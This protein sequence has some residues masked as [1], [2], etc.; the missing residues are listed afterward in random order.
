MGGD[1]SNTWLLT[2]KRKGE[3]G[4]L[5]NGI[6]VFGGLLNLFRDLHLSLLFFFWLLIGILFPLHLTS[7]LL[8]QFSFNLLS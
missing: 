8:R 5:K 3:E 2:G 7:F 6:Q 1:K 4:K